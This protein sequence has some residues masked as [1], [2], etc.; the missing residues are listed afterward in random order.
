MSRKYRHATISYRVL[1]MNRYQF[2]S[3]SHL[4][5]IDF[6]NIFEVEINF[7]MTQTNDS[8]HPYDTHNRAVFFWQVLIRFSYAIDVYLICNKLDEYI[9]ISV[10]L[11]R[12]FDYYHFFLLLA[13]FATIHNLPICHPL[14]IVIVI[15]CMMFEQ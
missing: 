3:K 10:L 6:C 12:S 11:F 1:M 7:E 8:A 9:I 15:R 4:S 2:T 13:S 14:L 5:E